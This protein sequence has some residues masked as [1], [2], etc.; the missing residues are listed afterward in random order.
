MAGATWSSRLAELGLTLPPVVPPLAAYQ[1]AV[2]TGD[3]VY[4][5]G[6]LPMVGGELMLRGK[7]SEGAAGLV[8]PDDAKAAS[9]APSRAPGRARVAASAVQLALAIES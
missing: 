8:A 5:A 7:V 3:L 9:A 2:R 1:P 6:Q 4:T